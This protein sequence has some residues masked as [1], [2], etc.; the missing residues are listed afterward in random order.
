MCVHI[1]AAC[2]YDVDAGELLAHG[3]D[4]DD[5]ERLPQLLGAQQLPEGP[6]G[7]GGL[8]LLLLPHLLDVERD[9]VCAAELHQGCA[10]EERDM[11]T[12][13]TLRIGSHTQHSLRSVVFPPCTPVS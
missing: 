1:A 9:L 2:T 4:A 10:R 5:V 11:L 8:L 3:E 7:L 6:L 13:R 12:L